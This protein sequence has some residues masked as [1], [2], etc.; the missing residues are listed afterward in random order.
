[1]SYFDSCSHSNH[2]CIAILGELNIVH[3]DI[4][5]PNIL[6]SRCEGE[7]AHYYLC[8]FD[9]AFLLTPESPFCPPMNHLAIETHCPDVFEKHTTEVDIWSISHLI[10]QKVSTS[11]NRSAS[12]FSLAM[13]IN[14]NY[15]HY[16]ANRI[17]AFMEHIRDNLGALCFCDTKCI[18]YSKPSI[19]INPI[20]TGNTG[21][22]EK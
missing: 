16:S 14:Q 2:G 5:W 13:D 9:D 11:D 21:A 8:D 19:S 1:L 17:L 6:K 15:K 3:N 7:P 18:D 22:E 4:R 12:L 10:Y 20:T